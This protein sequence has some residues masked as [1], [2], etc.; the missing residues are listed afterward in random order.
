MN[1]ALPGSPQIFM[2]GGGQGAQVIPLP[3]P[4]P[5]GMPMAPPQPA[6]ILDQMTPNR[7]PSPTEEIELQRL[8]TEE[9]KANALQAQANAWMEEEEE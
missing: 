5:T 7:A 9:A 3:I 4:W 1:P 8:K 6:Q 2:G